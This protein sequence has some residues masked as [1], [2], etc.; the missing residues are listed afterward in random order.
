MGLKSEGIM[1]KRKKND[2][3]EQIAFAVEKN[4][5]AQ[6]K[7][8]HYQKL[9]PLLLTSEFKKRNKTIMSIVVSIAV[10][11]II[12]IPI[13][14]LFTK[15]TDKSATLLIAVFTVA[16]NSLSILLSNWPNVIE[17]KQ[18]STLETVLFNLINMADVVTDSNLEKQ[19]NNL[20]QQILDK[21]YK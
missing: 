9:V 10:L 5:V 1:I 11:G 3:L 19:I 2:Y 21:M 6:R 4:E 20:I 17:Q 14:A 13:A 8:E 18:Y 15:D 12:A 7:F 16:L